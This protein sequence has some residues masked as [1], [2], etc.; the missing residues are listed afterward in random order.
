MVHAN[1]SLGIQLAEPLRRFQEVWYRS[2]C[3]IE[4]DRG[5]LYSLALP[6]QVVCHADCC[7]MELILGEVT[8]VVAMQVVYIKGHDDPTTDVCG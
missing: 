5:S 2:V 7:P 8:L 6:R 1:H 3:I 4:L